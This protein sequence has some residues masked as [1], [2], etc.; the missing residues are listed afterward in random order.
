MKS[1]TNII[2]NVILNEAEMEFDDVLVELQIMGYKVREKKV[3]S[4][5]EATK[6]NSVTIK[7]KD[8]GKGSMEVSTSNDGFDTKEKVTYTDFID[9]MVT[10]GLN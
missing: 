8:L 7:V 10:K 9:D 1:L 2:E 4:E 3:G 5:Y 6:T